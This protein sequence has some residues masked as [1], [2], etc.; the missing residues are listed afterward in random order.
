MKTTRSTTI[1]LAV[2]AVVVMGLGACGS[3]TTADTAAGPTTATPA[4]TAPVS[5]SPAVGPNDPVPSTCPE[6]TVTAAHMATYWGYLTYAIGTANDERPTLADLRMGAAA[7]QDLAPTCAPAAAASIDAFAATVEAIQ[8]I[9]TT[10]PTGAE[11]QAVND[12]LAAM[13]EAGTRMYADLGLSKFA[14]L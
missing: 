6:F 10:Q 9:Y 12:A 3:S 13:Q 8:P 1:T 4:A 2:A 7:L 14:W 5:P 11:V